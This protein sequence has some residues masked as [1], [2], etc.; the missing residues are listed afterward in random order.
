MIFL[1]QI[2]SGG[3]HQLKRLLYERHN[4]L[5]FNNAFYGQFS[6]EDCV[7]EWWQI[8]E[9]I[10]DICGTAQYMDHSIISQIYLSESLGSQLYQTS[11]FRNCFKMWT[12]QWFWLRNVHFSVKSPLFWNEKGQNNDSNSLSIVQLL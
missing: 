11:E 2:K 8:C 3:K 12:F 1:C 5:V 6:V 7:L 9:S 4:A 10:I